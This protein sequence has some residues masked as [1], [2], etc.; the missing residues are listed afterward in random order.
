MLKGL[1]NILENLQ[2]SAFM[3]LW[4]ALEIFLKESI[5]MKL[6]GRLEN[7]LKKSHL[8]SSGGT[9]RLSQQTILMSSIYSWE[10]FK[11]KICELKGLE[12]MVKN[13][14]LELHISLEISIK[15]HGRKN[16][17]FWRSRGDWKYSLKLTSIGLGC[18]SKFS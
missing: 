2:I 13:L 14:F 12:N 15:I 18:P 7:I 4:V 16:P 10:K 11:K 8:L 17:H 5:F 3:E 1:E 6:W 9:W